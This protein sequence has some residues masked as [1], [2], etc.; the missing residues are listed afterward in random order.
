MFLQ[1]LELAPFSVNLCQACSSSLA[2]FSHELYK[3]EEVS[4]TISAG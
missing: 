1:R 4:Y 2:A 3:G